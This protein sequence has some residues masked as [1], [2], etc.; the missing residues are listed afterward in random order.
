MSSHI[1]VTCLAMYHECIVSQ[2]NEFMILTLG[3]LKELG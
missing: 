2:A 1:D 3:S